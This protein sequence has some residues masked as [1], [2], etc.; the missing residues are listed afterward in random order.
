MPGLPSWLPALHHPQAYSHAAKRI[1][2][3]ETHLSWVFLTGHWAYKLKKPI[4]LGFV[5]FST[6]EKREAAC[7]E[8]LRLNR[9]TAAGLYED[10]VT[11]VE[12]EMGPRFGS[13]G[14]ILEYAVR[15]Q[16]FPQTDVLL[17]LADS[18]H[19]TATHIEHLAKAIAA[20]HA[21]ADVAPDNSPF[22]RPA[23]VR[24]YT[25]GC[26]PPIAASIGH[27]QAPKL[28]DISRWVKDEA[29]RLESH[30]IARRANG[31]VRECHGDLHLGNIVL[32]DGI[33]Q[34][35]DC[36]EFNAELRFI[37]VISDLAF[38]VM[39]LIDHGSPDFAWQALNGWLDQTGDFAGLAA[40]RYYEVYRALVRAKVAAIRLAQPGLTQDDLATWQSGL[41]SYLDLTNRLSERGQGRLV[42]MHGLSGSGK[43]VVGQQLAC[44]IGAICLRSD[45]ERKRRSDGSPRDVRYSEAAITDTYRRVLEATESLLQEGHTVVVDA[46]FLKRA[47]RDQFQDLAERSGV[48]RII[49]SCDAPQ[50]VLDER[51]QRRQ[52][53]GQD[54]SDATLEVLRSQ[55]AL[56]DPLT[57]LERGN[58]ILV[59]T[60]ATLDEHAL[61][62]AVISRLAPIRTRGT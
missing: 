59:D 34:P 19:L 9:R 20:M 7:R 47:H 38:L 10:V 31:F 35:F 12:T 1:E 58:S 2:L 13:G 32:V 24:R 30:F 17:S 23:T 52:S 51:V 11:L 4:A 42:L 21:A 60:S 5:D 48:P 44:Q 33:P 25:E 46:T 39:D 37:D 28:E 54:P 50:S 61:K 45:R 41:G 56:A 40:L 6:L 43:S 26:L 18:G 27:D 57:E 53:Q 29:T 49:V 15:M 62:Q 55:R 14:P 3:I 22:G 36:L 8:E 16:Q